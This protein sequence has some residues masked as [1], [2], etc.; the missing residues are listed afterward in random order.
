MAVMQ[1]GSEE[2]QKIPEL[3]PLNVIR[4]ETALSRYPVHRL[5]KQGTIGIEVRET[6]EAGDVLVQW[7][8]SHNS[9]FGQP[10]PLAYKIDTLIVNRRIEEAA[11]PIPRVIRLGTLRDVCHELGISTG[12]NLNTVK[13]ALYQNASA[14]ITAKLRYKLADKRTKE[15]EAGFT[16]YMVVFTGEELPDGRKADAVY[17]VL[18]EVFMQVLNGAQTRPLDYDYLKDLPPA[19]Q[20]LYELLSFQVYNALRFGRRQARLSYSEFC[21]YAPLTRFAKWDQVRPQMARIHRPHLKSGYIE[22]VEFEQTDHR[23]GKPDWVMV[24]IPG[25]K[26]KA[27]YRAF[28]KRGGPRVLEIEQPSPA[29]ESS[30]PT[31]LERELIS[32]GVTASTARELVDDYSQEHVTAQVEHFDWLSEHHPKKVKENPGGYLA[33]AIRGDY[34]PPKGFKTKAERA[35]ENEAK[36]AKEKAEREAARQRQAEREREREV[37][38]LWASLTDKEKQQLDKQA[39]DDADEETRHRYHQ[40]PPGPAKRLLMVPIRESYLRKLIESERASGS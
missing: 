12:E 4:V 32:R 36:E 35:R 21:T 39:L 10:G 37:S 3:A 19:A 8:V 24:Y 29:L 11:R 28:N 2:L 9:E 38:R 18:N 26:A 22:S 20:R 30:E 31:P 40:E 17:L 16:R 25:F 5:A 27:E 33:A 23:D 7:K 13:K 14:F 15:L 1:S 6:S 34:A